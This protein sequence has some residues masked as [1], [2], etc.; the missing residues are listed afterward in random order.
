M[1]GPTDPLKTHAERTA[2]VESGPAAEVDA[3]ARA[4]PRRFR[5]RVQ[6]QRFGTS[7][8]GRPLWVLSASDDGVLTPE[9]ARRRG[10]PVVFAL[11][12][13]HPGEIDGKDAGFQL[14]RE[15]LQRTALPGILGELTFVFVP[16]FN[17][18]GHEHASPDHRPNQ[19]GP[20][21][22][23]WRSNARNLNLN[24]DWMKA[25]SPE[26]QAI[27]PLLEA[28]DPLVFL[29]LH[30]TDGAHFQ[31]DVSLLVAPLY[32]G[33]PAMQAMARVLQDEIHAEL[34]SGGH[35]PLDFYPSLV[36]DDDPASGF[37]RTVY[38]PRFSHSYWGL[39]HR[40]AVLVETHSWKDYRT[41]VLTTRDVLA[42][43]LASVR[44]HGSPWRTRV[45]ALDRDTA[46]KPPV[47][48]DLAFAATE[49]TEQLEFPAY[50]YDR[51]PSPAT[52]G[53]YL[54]FQLDRPEIWRVPLRSPLAPTTHVDLP[55]GGWAVP[56]GWAEVVARTLDLH[57]VRHRRLARPGPA[58]VSV[59]Q[60]TDPP[61]P[62]ASYEGRQ[63]LEPLG[64]WSPPHRQ[65]LPRGTLVIP[66]AQKRAELA[67]HLLEPTAPDS[68]LAWGTFNSAFQQ[69]EYV[70]AYLLEPWAKAELGRNA[71]LRA[72]FE[73]RLLDPAF[74]A[75]PDARRRFFLIRHPS[76]DQRIRQAPVLRLIQ[77]VGPRG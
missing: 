7:G 12:G 37:S 52:G 4:F 45:H 9:K 2:Y 62:A 51:A 61:P 42:A 58:R 10:R 29:D 39:R 30:V 31:P 50:A 74:A 28:W 71:A 76:Y 5:G 69:Q 18:D 1:P 77:P 54:R 16:I 40:L 68:L 47:G 35:L 32:E 41:R 70:E 57:G 75:D 63:R 8:E 66:L 55:R 48:L 23:G 60:L 6:A 25:D 14:L 15:L 21:T 64:V 34:R 33:P 56:P 24:R 20:R 72:E 38:P 26:M 22:Q 11:A 13:I 43:T 67:A 36:R 65:K 3:L 46:R 17:V 19:N 49:E 73:Q 59:F 27:L 44:T 53:T